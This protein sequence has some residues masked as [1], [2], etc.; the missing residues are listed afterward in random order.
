MI[1]SNIAP[2]ELPESKITLLKSIKP[3]LH[4]TSFR[5]SIQ[6]K[7]SRF[8]ARYYQPTYAFTLQARIF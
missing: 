7:K 1:D 4:W 3:A 2:T 6:K 8:F 5:V